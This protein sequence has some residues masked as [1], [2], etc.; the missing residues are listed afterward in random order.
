MPG[1]KRCLH[2]LLQLA[3][4]F[5]L[6][7]PGVVYAEPP[8]I[9]NSPL[10]ISEVQTGGKVDGVENGQLEFIEL[11]NP[12]DEPVDVTDWRLEYLSSTHSGDSAPTRL[13]ATLSGYI[14]GKEFIVIASSASSIESELRYQVGN[15]SSGALA[16]SGGQLRLVKDGA[17][18]D[19]VT[20]GVAA[21]VTPWWRSVEIPANSSIQRILPESDQFTN[22][23]T[24]Y[25]PT[26]DM[27]P[28]TSP[29]IDSPPHSTCRGII[30][31]EIL[32]NPEGAD[33]GKEF[34]EIHNPSDSVISLKGCSIRLVEKGKTFALP[35]ESLDPHAYRAFYDGETKLILANAVS[36]KVSLFTDDGEQAVVYSNNLADNESWIFLNDQWQGT[37]HVTPNEANILTPGPVVDSR[38]SGDVAVPISCG[39]GKERHPETHRCRNISTSDEV[40]PIP[41]KEGYIRNPDT[42]RCRQIA[43]V[44]QGSVACKEHQERNPET[45][46]CRSVLA[47]STEPKPCIAGQE[48]NPTTNRCRKILPAAQANLVSDVPAA[49]KGIRVYWWIAAILI[50]CLG[51][52]VYEWRHDLANALHH[53]RKKRTSK[54]SKL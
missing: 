2:L 16:R 5:V 21:E 24:F 35:E 46:R 19:K 6:L 42:N 18:M 40:T 15:I 52:V 29:P 44:N 53:M 30:L 14:A 31:S 4:I 7:Y 1:M 32:P 48:R 17:T 11:Y 8:I 27:T 13:L 49:S 37:R 28:G 34:I 12:S 38:D 26:E 25:E 20:W 10:L 39:P 45:G 50:G 36:D 33:M 41:C 54:T 43:K 3:V 51:Y 9:S 22:G 23:F 47:V